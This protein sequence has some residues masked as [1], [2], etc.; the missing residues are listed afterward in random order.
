M[1]VV[2]P[3][4]FP[5]YLIAVNT[6]ATRVQ[7]PDLIPY[8]DILP[9]TIQI[10]ATSNKVPYLGHAGVLF[11]NGTS[12]LSKYYEYG[13]YD[14]AA[15]GLTRRV[16][17]SDLKIGADKKPTTDSLKKVLLTISTKAGQRGRI[18]G[19]YI[20]VPDGGF[21]KMLQYA[22]LRVRQNTDPKRAPYTLTGNSCM[23][24]A[25]K[26]A[27]AGGAT[28]PMII[29]PRPNSFIAEVQANYPKLSFKPPGDLLIGGK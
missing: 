16:P 28:I 1:D 10:K 23:H 21:A 26:V 25:K 12:G 7:V 20:E 5:D 24:F 8:F 4:A 2:I 9:D 3:M 13:R 11:F 19:A 27:E 18:E 17:I 14:R 29:D 15:L 6:P 22:V